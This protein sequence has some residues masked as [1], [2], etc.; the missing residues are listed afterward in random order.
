MSGGHI[1]RTNLSSLHTKV[2]LATFAFLGILATA[3]ALLVTHGFRETQ[4][5]IAQG[6]GKM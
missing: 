2:L 1:M 6:L 4:R 5:R 3:V